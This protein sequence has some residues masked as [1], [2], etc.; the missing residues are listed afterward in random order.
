MKYH[1]LQV[2]QYQYAGGV[3]ESI[4]Q[5]RLRP[6]TGEGQACL[7]FTLDIQPQTKC[8]WHRD[9]FGN[10]VATFSIHAKHSQLT[11]TASADVDVWGVA[12]SAETQLTAEMSEEL[13]SIEFRRRYAEYLAATPYTTLPPE[14]ATAETD[15]L[16][17]ESRDALDYVRR[18]SDFLY[19]EFTYHAG[20]TTVET[21]A[22]E[23]LAR[24]SGVCQDFT[25]LMLALCRVHQI[26]ARYVSGYLYCGENSAL[27]GDAA[28]HA[29]VEVRF[30]TLGW[31]G[32]DPTNHVFVGS[33]H[34][35]VAVG[36][37]YRDIV[38]IKGVYRGGAQT[39]ETSVRVHALETAG[40]Q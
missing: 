21:K 29:W 36:R 1:I 10:D 16:W 27:R 32:V 17:S 35:R 5:V 24:K 40:L 19:A 31:V 6:Y 8:T 11:V 39:L 28:M 34:I 25:H 18:I 38:P 37:D 30:P 14:A 13:T 23:F 7:D 4:N 20:V 9:Y 26:P 12:L 33:R 22:E 15:Q 2:N 3:T